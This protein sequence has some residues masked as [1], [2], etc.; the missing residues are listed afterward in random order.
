[1]ETEDRPY[2]LPERRGYSTTHVH[3]E[4]ERCS[5]LP[6]MPWYS[7]RYIPTLRTRLR[8]ALAVLR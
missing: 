1:M 7:C 6:E 2:A 5:I 3:E 4:G 8:W